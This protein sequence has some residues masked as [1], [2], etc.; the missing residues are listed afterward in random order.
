PDHGRRSHVPP[1][2][3]ASVAAF[4]VLP[5]ERIAAGHHDPT[6]S[7]SWPLAL[8]VK[9]VFY[10]ITRLTPAETSRNR[11]KERDLLVSAAGAVARLT[12][13]M[14]ADPDALQAL[15]PISPELALVDPELARR[16]RELLPD[17]QERPVLPRPLPVAPAPEPEPEPEAARRRWP[18]TIAL[19]VAIFV[20]G[21]VSG[22]FLGNHQHGSPTTQFEV[23]AVAPARTTTTHAALRPPAASAPVRQRRRHAPV[24]WA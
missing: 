20:A 12:S 17:P 7:A 13:V 22:T 4:P 14:D 23:R 18:R 11:R 24:A 19:A 1:F 9:S 3:R 8:G 16:A 15:G 5:A 10:T 6:P 2:S 21:A